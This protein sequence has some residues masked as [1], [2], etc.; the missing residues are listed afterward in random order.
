[1]LLAHMARERNENG[2]VRVDIRPSAE[3]AAYLD[4]LVALGIHGKTRSEVARA[5]VGYEIERLIR[6]GLL[7]IRAPAQRHN[8]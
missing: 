5:L 7:K 4:D 3:V 6:E 8:T 2:T 1:M